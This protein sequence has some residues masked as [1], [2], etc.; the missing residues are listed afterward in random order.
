M[1]GVKL[2]IFDMDGLMFDTEALT[3]R[4]WQEIGKI[5][6]YDITMDF[7]LGLLGMNKVSIS[8][9]FKKIYGQD[10]PFDELYIEQ[11][12]TVSRIIE[13]EGLGI[14]EGLV[15]LLNFLDKKKIKKAVATSSSRERAER[16]LSIAGVLD[17]F[18]GIICG[19][20]VTKGKP[21]PEI[22]LTVCKKLNIE[23]K[24]AIVF[25]DSER[26]LEAAVA[27]GIKCILIPDLVEPS[28]KNVNLAFAKLNS[29]ME[30]INLSNNV[31]SGN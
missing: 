15:E 21:D 18:D 17:R 8:G 12:K 13:E 11:G 24:D 9:Q 30:V 27:G 6:N 16:L 10:F 19:D 26:G 5:Y 31:E 25:E 2:A 23:P 1:D 4:A 14:K 7:L 22:F 20:E 29:L 28:D 3:K